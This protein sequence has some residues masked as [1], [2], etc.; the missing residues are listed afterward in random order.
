MVRLGKR[1]RKSPA[2]VL[3]AA[4]R[5]FTAAGIGLTVTQRG[6]SD[7]KL[8]GGGGEVT[9]TVTPEAAGSRHCEVDIVSHEWDVAARN[10]LG[11]I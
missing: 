11:K 10:F 2:Q 4:A 7:I 9:V 3:D 6:L 5:Y 8:E 1:S